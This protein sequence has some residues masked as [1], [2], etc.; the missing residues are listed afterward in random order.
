MSFEIFE[1]LKA[2]WLRTQFFCY[3]V[4]RHWL[5]V[6]DVLKEQ[7]DLKMSESDHLATLYHVTAEG[8]PLF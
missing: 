3:V 5:M 1:I 7:L 8:S 2:L 4:L 6:S